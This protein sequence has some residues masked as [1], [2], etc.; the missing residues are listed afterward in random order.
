[1]HSTAQIKLGIRQRLPILVLI[2]QPR[3]AILSLTIRTSRPRVEWGLDE[4]CWF[5]RSVTPVRDQV[6]V[7]D[8]EEVT[9]DFASVIQRLNQRF[10]CD[11]APFVHTPENVEAVYAELDAIERVRSDGG[12]IRATHVARPSQERAAMKRALAA[13]F[14]EPGPAAK[15]EVAN[16][17]YQSLAPSPRA[18]A[19]QAPARS[20][21]TPPSQ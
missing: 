3:D 7:A 6:V 18:S 20:P 19:S 14:D 9:T 4:Y 15:L 8:F 2:R 1:L 10:D 11:F 17:L 16:Q 21:S 12:E 5:Y 13:Q